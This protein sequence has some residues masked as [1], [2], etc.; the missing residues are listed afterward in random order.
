MKG[1]LVSP[2]PKAACHP[3]FK[4][5]HLKSLREREKTAR[6]REKEGRREQGLNYHRNNYD[7][8][9]GEGGKVIT[10]KLLDVEV[11]VG[12]SARP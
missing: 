11:L 2:V 7:P 6:K 4:D 1:F 9:M 3:P 8:G 10:S 5:T 12:N